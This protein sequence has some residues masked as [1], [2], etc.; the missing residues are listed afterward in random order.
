MGDE[1]MVRIFLESLARGERELHDNSPVREAQAAASKGVIETQGTPGRAPAAQ[2]SLDACEAAPPTLDKNAAVQ[3]SAEGKSILNRLFEVA[4]KSDEGKITPAD[5]EKKMGTD[6]AKQLIELGVSEITRH[7]NAS[8]IGLRKPVPIGDKSGQVKLG[9]EE[10]LSPSQNQSQSR[11][12]QGKDA[13]TYYV[14][15]TS[16]IYG[17]SASLED[18]KGVGGGR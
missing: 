1:I 13:P 18:V 8:T 16:A 11:A 4:A 17:G 9:E 15:F 6:A 10:S 5:F 14:S 7:G 3:A 12:P 2:N